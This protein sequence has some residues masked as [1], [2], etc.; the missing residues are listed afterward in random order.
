[1]QHCFVDELQ[2]YL[3]KSNEFGYIIGNRQSLKILAL[4]NRLLTLIRTSLFKNGF[5]ASNEQNELRRDIS[6]EL[7]GLFGHVFI[8]HC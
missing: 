7:L 4:S 5:S 1:M 3:K 6:F 2:K 8:L